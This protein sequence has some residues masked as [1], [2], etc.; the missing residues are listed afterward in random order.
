MA[1]SRSAD[2]EAVTLMAELAERGDVQ[3]DYNPIG[4]YLLQLWEVNQGVDAPSRVERVFAGLPPEYRPFLSLP[5]G[6][7]YFRPL[8]AK[9]AR[10]EMVELL[11]TGLRYFAAF[12]NESAACEFVGRLQAWLG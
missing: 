5:V 4:N 7:E 8:D 10:A 9:A 11:L 3:D 12:E 1:T 2:P 6:A